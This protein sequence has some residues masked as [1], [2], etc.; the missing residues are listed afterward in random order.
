MA[1][2]FFDHSS[3]G[4]AKVL[5]YD[6]ERCAGHN[7]MAGLRMAQRMKVRRRLD[8]GSR[9]CLGHWAR[10]IAFPPRITIGLIQQQF[11]GLSTAG[12]VAEKLDPLFVQHY[13]PRFAA[14]AG[15]YMQRTGVLVEISDLQRSKFA[16]PTAGE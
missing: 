1:V 4:V 8:V 5:G 3:I 14:L 9:T 12:Q 2:M 10:L 7:S 16:E 6:E 15:P 13:V 11:D